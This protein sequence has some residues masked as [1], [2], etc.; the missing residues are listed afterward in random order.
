MST[1]TGKSP[2]DTYKGLIKTADNDV[3]N[4]EKTLT[5]GDGNAL[6]MSV[7]PT[8]IGLSGDVKD[9]NG[10][11]GQAGQTLSQTVNGLEW[12]SKTY[13]FTQT[14][15]TNVWVINHDLYCFPSVTVIDSVGNICVGH[16]NYQNNRT[17]EVT[18]KTAF[19]G[20]AYLN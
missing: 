1:L 10:N 15:S 20:K 17:I 6:P 12:A 7:S 18:F 2:K 5:D 19:K 3:V 8:A 13:T 16:I 11:V 9:N 14:V 4:T